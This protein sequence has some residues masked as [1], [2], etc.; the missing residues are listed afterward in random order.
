[1]SVPEYLGKKCQWVYVYTLTGKDS[2]DWERHQGTCLKRGTGVLKVGYSQE[3]HPFKRVWD[4]VKTVFPNKAD[5]RLLD[6]FEAVRADG[7]PFTDRD[8]HS[9]LRDAGIRQEGEWFDAELDEV[10]AAVVAVR[11][12]TSFEAG[13]VLDYTLRPDQA[14]AVRITADY[15][16]KHAGDTK[17]SRFL[18]N[19]KMRFGKTFTTYKLAE[20]MKWQRVLVIT[21]KPA[22]RASWKADLEGHIDFSNWIFVDRESPSEC[23]DDAALHDGPV[24]WFASFQD[25]RGTDAEGGVKKHNKKIHDIQWDLIV[26]DEYHY[27]AWRDSSR[28]LHDPDD[29]AEDL[30]SEET[31]LEEEE[32]RVRKLKGHNRLYL[33]GTPFRALSEGEFIDEQIFNWTYV[34]EQRAKKA[35]PSS[36]E[37]NPYADLPALEIYSYDIGETAK[38]WAEEGEFSEFTLNRYFKAKKVKSGRSLASSGTYEFENRERVGEFLDMLRGTSGSQRVSNSLSGAKYPYRSVDFDHAVRHSVWYMNDVAS[39]CAMRDVLKGHPYFGTQFEIL[40]TAGRLGGQGAAAKSAV[41]SAL[42]TA[43]R[44]GYRSITLSC[45]KLMTGVTIPQ[46]GAIFM[47]RSLEAPESYF[48]AMFRVQSPWSVR[49]PGG[50]V[51]VKKP[52]AYVF[53]FDQNRVLSCL[54]HYGAYTNLKTGTPVE[55]SI[56]ELTAHLPVYAFGDGCWK[57]LSV[58]AVLEGYTRDSGVRALEDKFNTRF[59]VNVNNRT[60]ADILENDDL[61]AALKKVPIPR[62]T[63]KS[64]DTSA[65]TSTDRELVGESRNE[66][67]HESSSDQGPDRK[68]P[69]TEIDDVKDRVQAVVA[70]VSVFVYVS[71]RRERSLQDVLRTTESS[72][73]EEVVRVPLSYFQ[74]M[75]E[76]GYVNVSAV[77][78]GLRRFY[79]DEEHS[80][81]YHDPNY[82]PQTSADS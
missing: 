77:D 29:I 70:R 19:A 38:K 9:V 16:R 5:V 1:M 60:A 40:V 14:E 59:F 73:F 43:T 36:G 50:L 2:M 4:Q 33:S 56:E 8:V 22:V 25:L 68:P 72:L 6:Y 15:F 24:V 27:G 41:D 67:A 53:E 61:W 12:R 65:V 82:Q 23:R 63:D 62:K 45:G 31:F 75:C 10:R 44:T 35:W 69:K 26:V 3:N 64:S 52:T 49:E 37:P 79:G 48:Q 51:T 57:R 46:W 28:E 32:L 80:F 20:E 74:Q 55:E 18:W 78:S 42:D 13:R 39:C 66:G 81:N 71:D 58:R 21:H 11:H 54:G 47:L 34:D 30:D 7:T 17:A 76:Q